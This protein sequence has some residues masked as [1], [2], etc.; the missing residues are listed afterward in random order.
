MDNVKF[1]GPKIT[2]VSQVKPKKL[3]IVLHGAFSCGQEIL[4]VVGPDLSQSFDDALI[5]A[6]DAPYQQEGEAI[7]SDK[8]KRLWYK[9][10]P[11]DP[12]TERLRKCRELEPDLE[13]FID[14]KL[15]ELS[16]N[17]KDLLI[18][19]FSQGSVIGLDI[20]LRSKEACGGVLCFGTKLLDHDIGKALTARP[21]VMLVHG[22]EDATVPHDHSKKLAEILR[23][24][25]V[26]VG[27][28]YIPG[29]SHSI[30]RAARQAGIDGVKMTITQKTR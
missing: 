26:A 9:F 23:N 12:D 15:K 27:E 11:D 3:I 30:N 1:S 20:A 14:D 13:K 18:V 6:P 16:L 22:L 29:M 10:K 4:N 8:V 25:G 28:S 21:P 2:P 5:I 7:S 24:E 19:G 17:R